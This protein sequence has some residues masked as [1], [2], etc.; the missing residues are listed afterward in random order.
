MKIVGRWFDTVACTGVAIFASSDVV[1]VFCGGG[2]N[3]AAAGGDHLNPAADEISRQFG[4]PVIMALRPTE[5]DRKITALD[6]AEVSNPST[7]RGNKRC[8]SV[9]GACTQEPDGALLR[10]SPSRRKYARADQ[11]D[12]EITASHR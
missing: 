3:V 8:M 1:A 11:Q 10:S 6:K 4:E 12:D 7:E 2:H 9:G 5:F